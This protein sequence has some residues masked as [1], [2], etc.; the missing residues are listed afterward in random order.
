MSA[1]LCGDSLFGK[2]TQK[3]TSPLADVVLPSSLYH[4][5]TERKG[6]LVSGSY[7]LPVWFFF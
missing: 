3:D 2:D 4:C 6:L 5:Q 7:S 1:V